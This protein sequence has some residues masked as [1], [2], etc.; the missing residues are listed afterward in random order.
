MVTARLLVAACFIALS[1]IPGRAAERFIVL[2]ST[3]SM[4]QSGLFGHILPAFKA[5]TGIEVRVVAVGTGQALDI[6]RR[7]DADVV[8]VHDRE[9][10]AKFVAE[11]HGALR[12][13]VMYN[14]FILVGPRSDPAR[15]AGGKDAGAALK[16]IAEMGAV[17][18]SRGD[19]SG[20]HLAE[21]RLWRTAGV[22]PTQ[23]RGAWYREIGAG[24]GPTLNASAAMGAYTLADRGTWLSFK[25]R[26]DMAI[27]VE[28]DERLFNPYGVIAVDPRRHP[29]VRAEPAQVFVQWLL[30]A[31]GQ[32][33][34]A[35]YRVGNEPLFVPAARKAGS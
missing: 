12:H 23:A 4:E 30:S 16:R 5:K 3:T 14:D 35:S 2:A 11:G 33:A 10:E 17:F 7:G 27:L 34:I 19:R 6:A 32:A 18:V 21:M 26:A 1:A 28:G 31:E 8:L 25:N 15:V 20:T 9:A 13:D 24:M 29:H 22:E